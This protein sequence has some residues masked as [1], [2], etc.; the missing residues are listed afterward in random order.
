MR[1]RV[2]LHLTKGFQ[3]SD[4][5]VLSAEAWIPFQ[6]APMR[7][8]ERY[9]YPLAFSFCG[10]HLV[11]RVIVAYFGFAHGILGVVLRGLRGIDIVEK[12]KGD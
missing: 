8:G 11:L 7:L 6:K 10:M 4:T 5:L 9:T 3:M 12:R 2:A 1:F